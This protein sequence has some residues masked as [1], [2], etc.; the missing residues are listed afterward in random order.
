[1]EKE[2]HCRPLAGA[3]R[4][5]RFAQAGARKIA[6]RASDIARY[7]AGRSTDQQSTVANAS[8]RSK[9]GTTAT[10]D[11]EHQGAAATQAEGGPHVRGP[12]ANTLLGHL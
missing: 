7:E 8:P 1:M 6:R 2:T 10:D 5:S 11:S 3:K 4:N 12:G 9:G